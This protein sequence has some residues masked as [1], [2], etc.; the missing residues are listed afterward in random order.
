MEQAFYAACVIGPIAVIAWLVLRL[1]LTGSAQVLLCMDCEQCAGV[2]PLQ[3]KAGSQT[4]GPRDIMLAAKIGDP[5]RAITRGALQCTSCRACER[6]CPR[7]LA[8][9]LE[10]ERWKRSRSAG[11]LQNPSRDG[12]LAVWRPHVPAP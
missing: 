6:I 8:P 10:V 1:V 9:Y 3:K 11:R 4:L 12:S 2:C 5:E 7:G